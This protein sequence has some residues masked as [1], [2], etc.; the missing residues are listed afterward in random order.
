MQEY[1]VS[2]LASLSCWDSLLSLSPSL[3]LCISPLLLSL[4]LSLS[5]SLPSLS[6]HLYLTHRSLVSLYIFT[7]LSCTPF[8][9]PS[10]P[11]SSLHLVASLPQ[12]SREPSTSRSA[13]QLCTFMWNDTLFVTIKPPRPPVFALHTLCDDIAPAPNVCFLI[14]LSQRKLGNCL[15]SR[16]GYGILMTFLRTTR[17][18]S[19]S[20]LYNIAQF[21]GVARIITLCLSACVNL[22]CRTLLTSFRVTVASWIDSIVKFSW[23]RLQMSTTSHLAG[24]RY[25]PYL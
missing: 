23:P 6:P 3:T 19:I 12:A 17:V 8:L 9:S 7:L 24:E 25:P 15:C 22:F 2:F 5:L 11:P 18:H 14:P 20:P 1:D 21:D 13:K 4:S 10:L 16:Q